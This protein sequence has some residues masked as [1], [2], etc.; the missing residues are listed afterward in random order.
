MDEKHACRYRGI[1]KSNCCDPFQAIV[2]YIRYSFL[3][4]VPAFVIPAIIPHPDRGG[5]CRFARPNEPQ[6]PTQ[7]LRDISLACGGIAAF[8][9]GP[10]HID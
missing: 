8:P 5:R 1:G 3:F 9:V 2:A 7:T 4:P 10:T 6:M